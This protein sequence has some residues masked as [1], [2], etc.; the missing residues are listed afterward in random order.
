MKEIGFLGGMTTSPPPAGD[1]WR[2]TSCHKAWQWQASGFELFLRAWGEGIEVVSEGSLAV[3]LRG[4]VYDERHPGACDPAVVGRRILGAYARQERLPLEHLV[5]GFSLVLLDGYKGRVLLYRNIVGQVVPYYRVSSDGLTFSNNLA[6]LVDAAAE[7]PRPNES[8]LPA[9]F[10]YRFVPGRE[11]LFEDCFRLLPGQLLSHGP[12]GTRLSQ[13]ASL[14]G[15]GGTPASRGSEPFV[16]DET[17]KEVLEHYAEH[18]REA[19]NLLSGGVDSSYI[20]AKWNEVTRT[21]PE[22][23][24]SISIQ[25]R[26]P[27]TQGETEYALSA[28]N[29]FGTDHSLVDAEAP[30]MG[31]LTSFI[32]ETGEPPNHVQATYYLPLAAALLARGH[33]TG[34]CGQGADG[35]F[36]LSSSYLLWDATLLRSVLPGRLLSHGL[37]WASKLARIE[38]LASRFQLALDAYSW[39]EPSHP[40]NQVVVFTEP[41]LVQ[42]CF[43]T[44]AWRGALA[45]RRALLEPHGVSSNPLVRYHAMALLGDGVDSAALWNTA[46][47]RR[48]VDLLFPYLDTRMLRAVLGLSPRVRFPSRKPKMLLKRLLGMYAPQE[49]VYRKK[50]SF[51]QPIFEWLAPGGQLRLLAERVGDYAFV[52]QRVRRAALAEPGWFLYSLLCYDVWHKLFITRE[53]PR[54]QDARWGSDQAGRRAAALAG[55]R[56]HP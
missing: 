9:F 44:A 15:L 51:G 25:V 6:T 21:E 52:P 1:L 41:N 13:A 8:A 14:A 49:C 36:G 12:E 10:I 18:D 24:R 32:S 17:M 5:G 39:D 50:L 22:R 4:V 16:V 54:E 20:Q 56:R 23:P 42:A 46:A 40:I 35:L 48:G 55:S 34:L 28:S 11:T 7:S 53:L 43:G 27:R 29:W 37:L 31:Y 45:S 33:R 38:S 2:A 47:N 26:H 30:Y 19:V 3:L